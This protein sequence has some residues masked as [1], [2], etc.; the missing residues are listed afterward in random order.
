MKICLNFVYPLEHSIDCVFIIFFLNRLDIKV[1]FK[2]NKGFQYRISG[3]FCEDLFFDFF[4]IT[5]TLQK[6]QY[7]EII[8]GLF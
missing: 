3:N 2:G 8:S 1:Y 6:I 7:A 5:F 4:A